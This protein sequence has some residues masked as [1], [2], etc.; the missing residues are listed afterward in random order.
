MWFSDIVVWSHIPWLTNNCHPTAAAPAGPTLIIDAHSSVLNTQEP[1]LNCPRFTVDTL[2]SS[3][4]MVYIPWAVSLRCR[5]GVVHSLPLNSCSC[6]HHHSLVLNTRK[7]F[8]NCPRFTADTLPSSLPMVYHG[9][10][11]SD[12]IVELFI[13]RHSTSAAASIITPRC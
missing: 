2:P 9:Q 10:C 5:R 1:F 7:P 3:L 11:L 4:P 12:V 13:R 6:S 8:L